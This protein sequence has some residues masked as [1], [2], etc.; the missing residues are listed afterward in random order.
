[1]LIDIYLF[2]NGNQGRFQST[3][4]NPCSYHHR[5]W[6]LPTEKS[7]QLNGN[8]FKF[9]FKSN[10][11]G[12]YGSLP[13]SKTWLPARERLP[14][15][16]QEVSSEAALIFRAFPSSWQ[17]REF[18]F[19]LLCRGSPVGDLWVLVAWFRDSHEPPKHFSWR[20]GLN[21]FVPFLL[22]SSR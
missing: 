7:S 4:R 2:F 3:R 15:C 20:F 22:F 21:F 19:W 5:C 13:Q 1:M 18:V 10:N 11:F 17:P 9:S 16:P 8:W 12:T 6:F 14:A